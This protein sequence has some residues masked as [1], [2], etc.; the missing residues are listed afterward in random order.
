MKTGG[1]PQD[2]DISKAGGKAGKR[3]SVMFMLAVQVRNERVECGGLAPANKT[4]RLH[5][6]HTRLKGGRQCASEYNTCG[7]PA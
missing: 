5:M 3:G 7:V 6:Y 1:D 2:M 4:T